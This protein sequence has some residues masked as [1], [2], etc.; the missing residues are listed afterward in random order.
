MRVPVDRIVLGAVIPVSIYYVGR[1][2]DLALEGAIAASVWCLL[3]MAF[4]L[5]RRR[6]FDGYSAIGALY[7]V[8]ELA[9]L[10]VS[11]NPDWYL[12]ASIVSDGVVGA[13]FIFSMLA[14]RSLIQVLAE[15][16]AGL[17]AFPEA[18]RK[19]RHYRPLWLRLSLVWGGAYLA[20]GAFK[21]G[22]LSVAP[23]EVYL[24]VRTILDWPLT[25]V[26]MA[27]SFWYPKRYWGR[28]FEAEAGREA[29]S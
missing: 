7:G 1:K 18:V 26:L 22:V 15:Q 28:G 29:A 27:F 13:V 24:V 6:E 9:G 2:M 14:R 21:W 19:S 10:L 11:H 5:I 25:F 17:D 3:L 4:F 20:K 16:T 8:S 12:Y 23:V